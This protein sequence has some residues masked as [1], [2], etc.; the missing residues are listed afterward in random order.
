MF[1][2]K[3]SKQ[4]ESKTSTAR[5]PFVDTS[6]QPVMCREHSKQVVSNKSSVKDRRTNSRP[7]NVSK[8]GSGLLLAYRTFENMMRRSFQLSG[9]YDVITG[10]EDLQTAILNSKTPNIDGI[11]SSNFKRL[12]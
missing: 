6:E 2:F 5:F 8:L 12:R 4:V 3:R 11:H 10:W 7:G 9:S 1:S